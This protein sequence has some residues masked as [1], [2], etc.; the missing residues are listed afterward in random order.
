MAKAMSLTWWL[1]VLVGVAAAQPPPANDEF[2]KE[3]FE[4]TEPLRIV[5]PIHY[6]GTADLGA[7]LITTPAGH[8]LIDGA[9]RESAAQLE[10]SIRKLGAKPEEIRVL[11]I[12]QAHLDHVGTLA[13]FKKLSGARLAVMGPD[14]PL[15]RSG[16]SKDYLFADK[17]SYHFEPVTAD[18]V[19]K[20][21]DTVELGGI[22]L[23]AH[24]TP[25]HTPGCTTWTTTVKDGGR[26]YRVVFT[27]SASI[28]PGTRLVRDPSYPGIADDYRHTFVVLESLHPDVF[29]AAH[30]SFFDLAGKRGRAATEGSAAFV[31]PDGYRSRIADQ[32]AA[33]EELVAKEEQSAGD[34]LGGTTWRLV[35]FP[36]SDGRVLIPEDRKRYTI[37]FGTDNSLSARIDCNHGRGTWK[38]AGPGELQLGPLAL[39]RAMCPPGSLH[40]QIVKDWELVRSYV[41][42][43]G[44]LLISL[45]AD[46]GTY[47]FE[48][49]SGNSH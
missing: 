27:G 3:W 15:L 26:E 31:D 36:G 49:S 29:L 22:V 28:N 12:T 25:G 35:R 1:C 34:S 48:P 2:P 44:R 37:Q 9:M 7:Y 4:A 32:K 10:A 11:L 41:V 6:V 14:E 16:G 30:A 42:K 18:R 23:T 46:G 47:E 21:G 20:D 8:I 19:L 40:D 5:G 39:T 33:F 43:N 24:F 38:S 17:P 45:A 13:H